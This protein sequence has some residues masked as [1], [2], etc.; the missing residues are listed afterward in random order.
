MTRAS[1]AWILCEEEGAVTVDWVVLT[2]AVVSMGMIAG[3]IVW[4]NSG[5][6]ARNVSSYIGSQSVVTT[7]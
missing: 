1:W 2:A 3:T 7:F 5:S 4:T 6:V